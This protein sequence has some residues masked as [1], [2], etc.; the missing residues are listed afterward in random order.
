MRRGPLLP[1]LLL[2]TGA[3][4][5]AGPGGITLR[6]FAAC[7]HHAMAH[8][9]HGGHHAA[10][11]A[12]S[13]CWCDQM[14]GSGDVLLA[15]AVPAATVVAPITAA[16]GSDVPFPVPPSVS[17]GFIRAPIPRPPNRLA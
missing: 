7:R 6:A 17:P 16:A 14:T 4:L 1:I 3:W 2:A 13:P 10:L 11:P 15:P 9:S 5:A 8:A 12:G